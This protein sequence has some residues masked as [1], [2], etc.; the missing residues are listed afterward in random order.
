M[1]GWLARIITGD[2]IGKALDLADRKIQVESDK[3]KLKADILRESIRHQPDFLRAGGFWLIFVAGLPSIYHKA[4]VEIY[5]VHWCAGC[6]APKDWHI[7]S[8][9]P[10][11]DEYQAMIIAAWI[12]ALSIV[13]VIGRVKK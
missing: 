7:A 2:V 1:L 4:A 9:P 12:G 3:E 8:L 6:H 13:S 5:S 10:P 11:Y